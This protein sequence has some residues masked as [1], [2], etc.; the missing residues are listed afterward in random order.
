MLLLNNVSLAY[1]ARTLFEG[2]NAT[3]AAGEKV[4][5]VGPSGMGKSS[6]LRIIAGL[7]KP[8]SGSV[9]YQNIDTANCDDAALRKFRATALGFV[10]Q[11]FN[12]L[13]DMTVLENVLLPTKTKNAPVDCAD[14]LALLDTV[15]LGGLAHRY[16]TKLSGGEKQRVALCRALINRPTLVLADEP[17]GN[18]DGAASERVSELLLSIS[19]TVITVTHSDTV[20]SKHETVYRLASTKLEKAA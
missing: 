20:A 5:I 17:T 8:S 3:I 15:G 18:L 6:L 11:D 19:A 12:L 14:P 7:Q 1:G 16:P 13:D 2:V 4:A 9:V 10:Y